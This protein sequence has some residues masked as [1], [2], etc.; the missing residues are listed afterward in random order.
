MNDGK[1]TRKFSSGTRLRSF[2]YAFC[3][4]RTLLREEHNAIIH[5]IILL[6]V[7]AAG[8]FFG[9]S[10]TDWIAISIVSAFVLSTECFN[11]AI[12]NLSDFVSSQKDG[13]I[14]RVKDLAAAG[15]LISAIGA[16]VVGT[17]IFLP[18]L[19]ELIKSWLHQ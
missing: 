16:A 8:F 9:I 12:E 10:K 13:R 11:S 14:K 4:L 7:I 1:S 3:G 18:E 19:T 5:I 15:V 6:L 2:S 17:I